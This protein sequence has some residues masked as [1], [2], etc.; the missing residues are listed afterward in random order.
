MHICVYLLIPIHLHLYRLLCSHTLASCILSALVAG[1]FLILSALSGLPGPYYST[2]A[3]ILG[4]VY[5]N[6]LLAIL[7]SRIRIVGGRE[8][9]ENSNGKLHISL[10]QS[11]GISGGSDNSG[12]QRVATVHVREEVWVHS[13]VLEMQVRNK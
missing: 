6:S 12:T 3:T 5:S 10:G 1:A 13:D 4:K 8:A 7:N 11:T 2:P 9:P